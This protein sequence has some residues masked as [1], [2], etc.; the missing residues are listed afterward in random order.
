MENRLDEANQM[1][2]NLMVSKGC[3]PDIVTLNILIN[4]YCKAKRVDDG[5]TLF[6]NMKLV[7]N[8]VTY[9]TLVQGF[10]RSGKLNVAK[11]LFQEMVSEGAH[12]DIVTYGILLDGLCDNGELEKALEILDQMHNKK[13]KED[14]YE[15]NFCTYNTII[16]AHLRDGGDLATSVELI[17]EMN[18]CGFS[19][20]A[21]TIKMVMDML[22]DGRLDKSFLDMLSGPSQDKSSLLD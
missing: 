10:C 2:K 19:A 1:M 18:R 12:P 17:E 9:N 22:V 3:D 15:P 6:R 5:M 11:E 4:G 16:R 14:G 7:A 13:M 8:T 21:S 20:D